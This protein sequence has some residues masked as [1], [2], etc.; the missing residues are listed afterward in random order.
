M[1]GQ[2]SHSP[3]TNAVSQG[4]CEKKITALI[5]LP[6]NNSSDLYFMVGAAMFSVLKTTSVQNSR[7]AVKENVTPGALPTIS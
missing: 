3:Q 2:L 5:I 7:D 4:K 6:L 1:K